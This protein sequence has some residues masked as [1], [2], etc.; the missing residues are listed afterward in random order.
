LKTNT[1]NFWNT[2]KT[3]AGTKNNY[4]E[5]KKD[6]YVHRKTKGAHP[7]MR[8]APFFYLLPAVTETTIVCA[9]ADCIFFIF[10]Q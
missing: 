6:F 5:R 7:E 10:F 3:A 2:L 9:S 1:K 4:G 8:R